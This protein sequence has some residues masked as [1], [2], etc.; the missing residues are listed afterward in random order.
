MVPAE[1]KGSCA[2]RVTVIF[3]GKRYTG[4]RSRDTKHIFLQWRS[5]DFVLRGPEN[6]DAVCAEFQTPKATSGEG[7][8]PPQPTRGSGERRKLFQRG[9]GGDPAENGFWFIL[10]LKKRI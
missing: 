4:V 8:S 6:R 5:Q 7:V 2:R 9:P 1:K 10:G 3:L